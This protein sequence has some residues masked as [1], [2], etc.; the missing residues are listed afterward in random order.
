M[1]S[2]TPDDSDPARLDADQALVDELRRQQFRGRS[3][4]LF[5]EALATY[6]LKVMGPWISTLLIFRRCA[7]KGMPIQVPEL[8]V[9]QGFDGLTDQDVEDLVFETVGLALKG[10]RDNVLEPGGWSPTG[11]ASLTTYFIG[12][13]LIQF[14]GVFRRWW[15][16]NQHRW[17][18]V[19]LD[20][21]AIDT[22]DR[23][24]S[25]WPDWGAKETVDL[26]A[27]CAYITDHRARRVVALRIYGFSSAE[28][29]EILG[30][31]TKAVESL[32]YRLRRRAAGEGGGEV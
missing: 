1:T 17:D 30:T 2:A 8:L 11:G 24:G 6:G 10:F 4:D 27:L 22:I 32:L 13:C 23:D 21:P 3:W 9:E 19:S 15:R 12:Q 25:S 31:T 29:A 28:A 16:D 20:D 7:S 14:P 26:D 18:T 5:A